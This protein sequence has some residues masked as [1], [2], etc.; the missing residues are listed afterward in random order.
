MKFPTKHL[1]G[2]R[3]Q[4]THWWRQSLHWK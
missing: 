2:N 1:W 4:E 3:H